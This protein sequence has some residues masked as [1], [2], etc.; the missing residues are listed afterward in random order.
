MELSNDLL[1]YTPRQIQVIQ[2]MANGLRYKEIA[3]SL[4]LSTRTVEDHVNAIMKKMHART[5]GEIIAM[6]IR[7]G[8]IA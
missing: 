8:L 5:P 1:K 7:M 6:G 3:A 2:G 4:G